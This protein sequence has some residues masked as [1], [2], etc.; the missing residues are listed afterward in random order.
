M[1]KL[2]YTDPTGT[3]NAVSR[4]DIS[5]YVIHAA[6]SGDTDQAARKLEFTIAYNT[7]EKD[8]AFVPLN[9]QLGGVIEASK[10]D[11]TDATE[12][13]IFVGRIFFRKRASDSFTFEFT[14]YDNMVYL[15]KSNIRANFKDIDV[16]SAIKQVCGSIGLETADSIPSIPTVVN[17]IADDKS[18]TEVLKMLFDKAKADQGKDYRAISI[19][20]KI[21]V[22]EKSE[23]IENYIAD[24]SVNVISA[25][26]SESLEDMVDKVVAVNDDGS[27]G[28]IFT[29]DDEIGKYGTI[30]KIYKIQPPKSGESV[31]NVTA[32]KA[33]LKAPKEE[34]SLKALGNI[35]CI[36]GYA[37]TVQE[38]QLKGKFAIKS[39]THHFENGIH[40]MDLT[41]EY[42]GEA[43]K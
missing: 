39:D 8:A 14:C 23:T 24:S 11:E 38:E 4:Q 1:L 22:V 17:F 19:N 31:D 12:T 32:A 18:G 37:I 20:E 2:Y 28:Q 29:T 27:V 43:E 36:S 16:T 9:L 33:L 40:T 26:H 7:A 35:Q 3:E 13:P 6:W 30:Q 34:S 5:N 15:A 21:T 10:V 42:I 25:E 41:L